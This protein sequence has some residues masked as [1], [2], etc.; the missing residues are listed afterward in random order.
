MNVPEGW[1]LVP[2]EP[3]QK[4]CAAGINSDNGVYYVYRAMLA[5]APQPP[6]DAVSSVDYWQ[7]R[8]HVVCA[9]CNGSKIRSYRQADHLGGGYVDV[10]CDCTY[11]QPP[12]DVVRDAEDARRYRYI[13]SA[14]CHIHSIWFQSFGERFNLMGDDLDESIDAAMRAGKEGA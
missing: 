11:T 13:R 3:T 2:I 7:R 5:V 8:G 4:M 1:K 14:D 9:K 10:P 12:A 6:A